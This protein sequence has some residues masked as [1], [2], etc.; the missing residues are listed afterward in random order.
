[1]Y[2]A[3]AALGVMRNGKVRANCHD[4][5]PAIAPNP[6]DRRA[7]SV[8]A[9]VAVSSILRE[10]I[11]IGDRRRA[12]LTVGEDADTPTGTNDRINQTTVDDTNA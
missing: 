7:W 6:N 3:L 8:V 2:V 12:V 1:M 10:G 11:L 9:T 5:I 4:T